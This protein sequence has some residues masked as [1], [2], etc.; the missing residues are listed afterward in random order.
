MYSIYPF[1]KLFLGYVDTT[2]G[3][4]FGTPFSLIRLEILSKE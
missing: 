3:G 2:K 4:A 1:S